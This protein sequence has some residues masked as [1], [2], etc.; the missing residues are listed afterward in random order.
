[1]ARRLAS[2]AA[3]AALLCAT[4]VQ[5]A[6]WGTIIPGETAQEAV[7]ARFG[8]PTRMASQKIDG[9]DSGQWIYEGT[10]APAGF[11]RATFDFGILTPK[12]YRADLVRTIRLEP[13]PGI[14]TR[15][16]VINGW[17]APARLGKEKD[18][19]VFFYAEGL[20]V[21]FS[22]DGWLAETMVFTPP[23]K[24]ADAAAPA[25]P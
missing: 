25:K 13:R 23:Q 1:M 3:V 24:T 15:T 7:R 6:E 4:V 9:Y 17:G 8:G 2:L 16:T 12:G 18:A 20:L 22:K 19:D 11:T 21:F 10:Q 5:A 14:F